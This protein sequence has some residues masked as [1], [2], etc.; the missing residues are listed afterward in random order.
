[1]TASSKVRMG[2]LEHHPRA[3]GSPRMFGAL[4]TCIE[5]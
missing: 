5:A 2:R 4:P 3:I 1:M